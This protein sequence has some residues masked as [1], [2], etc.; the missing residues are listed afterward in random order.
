M[1]G[2]FGLFGN[3]NDKNI[4]TFSKSVLKLHYDWP[5]HSFTDDTGCFSEINEDNPPH[6]MDGVSLVCPLFASVEVPP[7]FEKLYDPQ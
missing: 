2:I 6:L 1:T 3:I 5:L 4:E 7:L